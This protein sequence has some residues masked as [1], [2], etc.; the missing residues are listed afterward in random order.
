MHRCGL[1]WN[2]MDGHGHW[3]IMQPS[4]RRKS[5]GERKEPHSL[6]QGRGWSS[7]WPRS[8]WPRL[9]SPIH[10]PMY[11][12]LSNCYTPYSAL[13]SSLFFPHASVPTWPRPNGTEEELPVAAPASGIMKTLRLHCS[14]RA[15]A[16]E[17][18][19]IADTRLV[20]SGWMGGWVVCWVVC[21]PPTPMPASQRRRPV[22]AT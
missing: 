6:K 14:A 22:V 7:M 4:W 16:V 8:T 1:D 18:G 13:L 15:K 2:A 11:V 9:L 17:R 10:I 12:G 3:E 20:C 19:G 5:R 21:C